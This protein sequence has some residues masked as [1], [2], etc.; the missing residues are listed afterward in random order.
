MVSNTPVKKITVGQ[1]SAALWENEINVNGQV[2]TVLKASVQRR[3]K[4]KDGQ[5]KS[6]QSFSR[7]EVPFVL[8]TLV[9]AFEAMAESSEESG[10]VAYEY[11][12]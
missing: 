5:W 9:K 10:D 3:Y 11:V 12:G 8:Y 4:D 7:N 6:S 2:R 1:V